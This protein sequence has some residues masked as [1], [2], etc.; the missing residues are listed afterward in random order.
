M[1]NIPILI[2]TEAET[3]IEQD[4]EEK[5]HTKVSNATVYNATKSLFNITF[6]NCKFNRK[7]SQVLNKISNISNSFSGR[8]KT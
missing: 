1:D 7:F 2:D 6:E 8:T 3:S 5:I 4:V